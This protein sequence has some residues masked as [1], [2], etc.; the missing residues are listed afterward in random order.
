VRRGSEVRR[1]VVVRNPEQGKRDRARREVLLEGVETEI[2]DVNAR[3]RKMAATQHTKAVCALRSHA[4][5]GRYVKELKSGEL[6]IDRARV[7]EEEKLDGKHLVSTTD[8]SLSAEEVA[9]GYKQLAEVERA[10][11]TL[12]HT[13]ELRPLHHRLPQRIEAHVLLCWLALLLIRVIENETG[14]SWERI[15]EELEQIALV[16]LSSKD[17]ALQLTTVLSTE[18]RKLLNQLTLVLNSDS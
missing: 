8:P 16:N 11:R 17:G 9:L 7:R 5:L 3:R 10:F 13:L 4:T 18:Q 12:K 14:Q 2:A 6:R 15:R 1:F